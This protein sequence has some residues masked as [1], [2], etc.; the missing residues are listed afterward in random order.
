MK[1]CFLCIFLILF[2]FQGCYI[3]DTDVYETIP[4]NINLKYACKYDDLLYYIN[5]QNSYIYVKQADTNEEKLLISYEASELVVTNNH[6][7]FIEETTGNIYKANCDGMNVKRIV[8]KRCR[9][10][11]VYGN[12]AY[13]NVYGYYKSNVEHLYQT[14]LNSGFTKKL[15]SNAGDYCIYD[16][17]IYFERFVKYP[18]YGQNNGVADFCFAHLDGTNVTKINDN[19]VARIA[20]NNGYIYYTNA[21]GLHRICLNDMTK[22]TL[23]ERIKYSFA[24]DDDYVYYVDESTAGLNRIY[25]RSLTQKDSNEFLTEGINLEIDGIIDNYIY[26]HGF[27]DSSAH[28]IEDWKYYFME[29][30]GD[31]LETWR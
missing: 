23:L 21:K 27:L 11:T 14:N 19:E 8:S 24:V 5:Q 25:R 10:L 13:Y 16:N 30:G 18:T 3:E 12:N 15:I 2:L 28:T 6:I 17:K 7:Y 31:I 22:E 26:F 4:G 29:I 1:K 9:N 20:E